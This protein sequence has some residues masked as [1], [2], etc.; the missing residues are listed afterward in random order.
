MFYSQPPKLFR[1]LSPRRQVFTRTLLGLLLASVASSLAA[2]SPYLTLPRFDSGGATSEL[3]YF[4]LGNGASYELDQLRRQPTEVR[5]KRLESNLFGDIG[6]P[7][8]Q[9]AK[10][11]EIFLGP[12]HAPDGSVRTAMFVE[13]STGY[14]TFFKQLGKNDRLGELESILGRPFGPLAADDGNFALLMRRNSSGRTDG[15]YLYHATT[16]QGLYYSGLAKITPEPRVAATE[17]LPVLRG[18]IS[19]AAVLAEEETVTYAITDHASNT[20]TFLDVDRQATLRL[21]SRAS[22]LKLDELFG[23]D[24]LRPTSNRYLLIPINNSEDSTIALVIVDQASGG[25]LLVDAL[26]AATPRS[27]LM[28]GNIYTVLGGAQDRPRSL[29]PVV[30]YDSSGITRGFW[31]LDSLTGGFVF[32]S[33][34]ESPADLRIDRVS[35]DRR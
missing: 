22:N 2:Q 16:G 31:L 4:D 11:G 21:P 25:L 23:S 7:T 27:R 15:A 24:N 10:L 18:P 35:V 5:S 8:D 9:P 29:S 19:S 17:A 20:L 28:P 32:V 30:A 34:P 33:R 13:T 6:R 14:V 26:A 3:F 12:L 1:S